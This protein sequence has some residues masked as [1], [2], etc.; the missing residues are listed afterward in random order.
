MKV[1][2]LR[3]TLRKKSRFIPIKR[4]LITICILFAILPLL[5]LNYFSYNISA[6]AL[7]GT[8]EQLTTQ[9]INQ[10]SIN[11]NTFT[12][13]V[14]KDITQFI[15]S[16]FVEN[17]ALVNYFSDNPKDK[18][19]AEQRVK[20]SVKDFA[21]LNDLVTSVIIVF[22]DDHIISNRIDLNKQDILAVR[23][24]KEGGNL[25]W[26][27]GTGVYSDSVYVIRELIAPLSKGTCT[28]CIE[29]DKES[30]ATLLKDVELLD[31]S[32]IILMD[33]NRNTIYS[34]Q[35]N[36]VGMDDEVWTQLMNQ[37]EPETITW[38]HTLV[39]YTE[40]ANKWK[41]IAQIPERSLTSQLDQVT[42]YISV[43]IIAISFAAVIVG[44]NIAKKFSD[45]IV[46]LM[47]EMKRA[48]E[49]DLTVYIEPEGNNEISNLC[50]SFNYMIGNIRSLL[51]ETKKV[52]DSSLEDSKLLSEST[53]YSVGTFDQ[54]AVSVTSIA[55][56]TRNQAA[57]AQKGAAAMETLSDRIQ[58]VMQKSNAVYQNSQGIRE[59]IRE[60]TQCIEL[61]KSAVISTSQ[62]NSNIEHSILELNERNNNIEE[63]INLI[64]NI[65]TQT[66]LLAL[67]AS[68]E[69]ARAGEAGKGFAVVASEV[70]HLAE[71]SKASNEK[72]QLVLNEIREK[73]L[74]TNKLI[75]E[76]NCI[77]NNQEQ[78]V[79][80]A[81]HIFFDIIETLKMMDTELGDINYQIQD[82]KELK[83]ETQEEITSI[84][85][86]VQQFA[87]ATEEVSQLS[88]EQTSVIN[89]L[90]ELSDRLTTTMKNLDGSIQTFNLSV[91]E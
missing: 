67:N 57:N 24:L 51:E 3:R 90:A 29:I 19:E 82:I 89:N 31:N 43:F 25:V 36:N 21:N 11:V 71:Q 1:K 42:I 26:K 10:V 12:S 59:L 49:G 23:D 60:A 15:V 80:K 69:A 66:N 54:L 81:S 62:M 84:A 74:D 64:N 27:K 72:I 17:S 76:S 28:V 20:K 37:E 44:L 47:K 78:V 2:L 77:F 40:L 61:L 30:I 38:D 9:M 79:Q 87:A 7:R 91:R 32:S 50:V 4:R 41:L 85:S 13:E 6:N 88:E 63:M 35:N 8:S 48:E 65:S 22:D 55:D 18:L 33:N 73:T 46:H 70:R 75:K 5:I 52:V 14:E 56:G 45:P 34:N 86:I 53:Q 16:S 39:T 68:I 58:L 83:D